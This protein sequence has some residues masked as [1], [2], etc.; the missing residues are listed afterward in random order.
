MSKRESRGQQV[1]TFGHYVP[2]PDQST[3]KE[4]IK[5][6][7]KADEGR[8]YIYPP[9]HI[10]PVAR[11]KA[12]QSSAA[13]GVNFR[14]DFINSPL[15]DKVVH[16]FETMCSIY[17]NILKEE[18]KIR[19]IRFA[20]QRNLRADLN[21][22]AKSEISFCGSPALYFNYELLWLSGGELFRQDDPELPLQ[23]VRS[24]HDG[25]AKV[26]P[27]TQEREDFFASMTVAMIT[28]INRIDDFKANLESNVDKAIATRSS[29]FLPAPSA[30]EG[31]GK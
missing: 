16:A 10:L 21:H 29:L 25:D 26:I 23:H 18:G 19:V 27:W 8:F 5:V 20:V 14:D 9:A 3:E 1:K 6:Y 4:T 2:Q 7:F 15:M 31:Y 11:A 13:H 22:H 12:E 28:L 30:T 17:Q 24:H